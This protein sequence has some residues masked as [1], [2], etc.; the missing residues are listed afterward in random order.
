MTRN[1]YLYSLSTK[2]ILFAKNDY[3]RYLPLDKLDV[4]LN[5][6]ENLYKIDNHLRDPEFIMYNRYAY[7]VEEFIKN[8]WYNPK[9]VPK[10]SNRYNSENKLDNNYPVWIPSTE[11]EYGGGIVVTESQLKNQ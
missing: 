2:G 9:I 7:I 11:E 4:L 6:S 1:L 3:S 5:L 10:V 8:N